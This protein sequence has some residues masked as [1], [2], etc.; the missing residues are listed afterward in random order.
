MALDFGQM[1]GLVKQ[2]HEMQKKI[3]DLQAE[4]AGR[5]VTATS[6]GGMV[7][8]TANGATEIVSIKFEREVVNPD[9]LDMLADLTLA[10]VNEAI[11]KAQDMV[12]QEMAKITGGFKLPG[13]FGG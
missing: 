13:L 2:A 8:A 1:G 10:A 3:A 9:E 7:T 4:L 11:K 12:A 6:G 5:T